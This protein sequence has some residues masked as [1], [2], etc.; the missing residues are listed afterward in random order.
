MLLT[1]L[2]LAHCG[3]PGPDTPLG[4]RFAAEARSLDCYTATPRGAGGIRDG[5]TMEACVA[6]GSA[7][8]YRAWLEAPVE[9]VFCYHCRAYPRHR[10]HY[11]RRR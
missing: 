9:P 2:A 8:R 6:R 1:L 4:R 5:E 11:S 10:T 3:T 7:D